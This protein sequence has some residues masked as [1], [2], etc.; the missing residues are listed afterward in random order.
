[1]FS[2]RARLSP[3]NCPKRY[4][5]P[6]PLAVRVPCRKH[7]PHAIETLHRHSRHHLA[8]RQRPE[9]LWQCNVTCWSA[10]GTS[11]ASA[12]PGHWAP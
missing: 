7:P 1:M 9:H 6:A 12:S 3:F 11:P 4:H 2:R 8:A 10:T 5:V